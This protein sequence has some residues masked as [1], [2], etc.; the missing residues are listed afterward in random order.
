MQTWLVSLRVVPVVAG[1]KETLIQSP[2]G[3]MTRE[4]AFNRNKEGDLV[5]NVS[6]NEAET[7]LRMFPKVYVM[8]VPWA[9][10]DLVLKLATKLDAIAAHLGIEFEEDDAT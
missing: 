2:V 1:D 7:L 6:A 8:D 3:S 10:V 5:A 4:I 9:P